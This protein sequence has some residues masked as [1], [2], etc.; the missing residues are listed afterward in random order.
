MDV[1]CE[2]CGAGSET[3][4]GL[5]DIGV[6]DSAGYA[7]IVRLLNG[8][9]IFGS[10]GQDSD[11][12][13]LAR[14]LTEEDGLPLVGFDEGYGGVRAQDRYRESGETGSGSDVGNAESALGQVR[15]EK[16]GLAVMPLYCF[17]FVADGA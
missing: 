3:A 2:Q 5:L 9:L 12:G 17:G 8:I 4:E 6:A 14:G 16:D 15:G 13:E 10:Y 1:S 11:V 7:P